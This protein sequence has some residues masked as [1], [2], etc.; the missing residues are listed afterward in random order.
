[1]V[2]LNHAKAYEDYIINL[3]RYFHENP[4]LGW[5]EF[6]TSKKIKEELTKLG[7]PFVSV[8]KTGVIAKIEGLNEGPTIGLRSDMDALNIQ[9][10]TNCEY[11]SRNPGVM[12]ACGHDG[13]MA[14]LLGAA[15]IINESRSELR[16]TVKII[17]Q[18]AEEIIEGAKKVIDSGELDD[19]DA[20][21]A[22]HLWPDI[23]SGKMSIEVGPRMASADR[24]TMKVLGKSGHGSTPHLTIDALVVASAILLNLQSIVS[25]EID[26]LE[27]TVISVG[28]LIAGNKYN[29]IANEA[30]MEGTTRCFNRSI[31]ENLPNMINRIATHTAESYRS[32]VEFEYF[33]GTPPTINSENTTIHAIEAATKL[34]GKQSLCSLTKV[35]G[36]EDFA[37]YLE[38]TPGTIIFLGV[39][40]SNITTYPFHHEKYNIDESVLYKGAALLS[41]I[42]LDY[43]MDK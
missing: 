7:I 28:K 12:H 42:A 31:R 41:Q 33:Y 26:P 43:R 38:K 37:M 4:E 23:D 14:M 13:H 22:I 11:M 8:A 40:N 30:I 1:M 21:Y 2:L 24:F 29:I 39:K 18:P 32:T 5:N 20:I 34:F 15:R 19:L 9:E 25:R 6:N 27:P 35:M 36:G 16:G 3:R 10:E 17:F